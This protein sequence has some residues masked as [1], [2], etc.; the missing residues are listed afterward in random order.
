MFVIR[1]T[2]GLKKGTSVRIV[3]MDG[4]YYFLSGL[5]KKRKIPIPRSDFTLEKADVQL[6][7]LADSVAI[8]LGA[9]FGHAGGPIGVG[10]GIGIGALVGSVTT[11]K[12]QKRNHIFTVVMMDGGK[13]DLMFTDKELLLMSRKAPELSRAL[14]NEIINIGQR[15]IA[16][17]GTSLKPIAGAI[18]KN[19]GFSFKKQHS[20]VQKMPPR[21]HTRPQGFSKKGK[22]S[23]EEVREAAGLGHTESQFVLGEMY[24]KGDGV[25]QEFAEA[26]KWYRMAAEKGH[27]SAQNKLGLMYEYGQYVRQDYV[28]AHVWYNLSAA[29]G[30]IDAV[31]NRDDLA[32]HMTPAQI[33][34]AQR[35]AREWWEDHQ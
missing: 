25:P 31:N 26:I 9:T 21:T 22:Y 23:V 28:H 17:G 32:E 10:I 35:L 5:L 1:N 11:K 13:F 6:M 14:Q 8:E 33:A 27:A 24:Q 15:D 4:D 30:K 19:Q 2:Y 16:V 3:K 12:R 7:E 18:D 29:Q 34:E 20:A